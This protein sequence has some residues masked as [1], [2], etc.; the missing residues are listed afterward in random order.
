MADT[1]F[2]V[3]S[4][5]EALPHLRRP[6]APAAVRWKVQV[7]TN[8]NRA[9]IVVAHIDA[10]L[11]IERLNLVA[12]GAWYDQYDQFAGA[13]RCRLA[14]LGGVPREDVGLGSDQKAQVSDAL[15]RAGV[16]YGIGVSIYALA[17]VYMEVGGGPNKL[18]TRKKYDQKKKDWIEVPDLRAENREW[19]ADRYAAWLETPRAAR[20]R[21]RARRAGHGR[22]GRADRVA[23]G[24][25]VV[26]G[27][28]GG[29]RGGAAAD[30]RAGAGGVVRGALRRLL[31]WRR[32]DPIIREI[33]R[34][35][36]HAR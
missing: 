6:F 23:A 26:A 10:R 7:A 21:R 5:D 22:R 2:P 20:A 27:G 17:Q 29:A 14:V 3:T 32:R 4:L 34:W 33:E 35:T 28:G 36:G 19:L 25:G 1:A 31:R 24:G 8:N 13:M 9:G 11:V 12:G 16:K 30:A 18:G 15:K